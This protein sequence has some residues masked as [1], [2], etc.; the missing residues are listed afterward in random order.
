MNSQQKTIEDNSDSIIG[1]LAAQCKD[2][3]VLLSLARREAAA[4]KD[5]NFDDLLTVTKERAS[6]TDRLEIYHKQLADLRSRFEVDFHYVNKTTIALQTQE[7]VTKIQS[8]CSENLQMLLVSRNNLLRDRRQL[9]QS[10]RSL[11]AY[12]QNMPSISIAYDE[13][14]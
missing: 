10:R 13:H 9:D 8:Q 3:E 2:L 12:S 14:I 7:L 1:I 5:N 4:L 11:S 6:L